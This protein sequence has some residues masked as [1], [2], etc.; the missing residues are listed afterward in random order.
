[1]KTKIV[2]LIEVVAVFA[3]TLTVVAVVG[4]STIGTAIRNA[5]DRAFLEYAAMIAVP[6]AVLL[7]SKRGLATYGLSLLNLRYHLAVTLTA[8]IPVAIASVA[9]V[10][11]DEKGWQGALIITAIQVALLFAIALL[12]RRK[13]TLGSA[14]GLAALV[15]VRIVGSQTAGP[16]PEKAVS[17]LVFYVLFLGLGEELLFRGYIQSRLNAAFGRPFSFYGVEWGWGAIVA[18]ALFG[19]MHVLNLGSY[20]NEQW[21]L[22]PWWGLWTFFG[23][24]VLAFVREKTGSI[25]APTLLH[26]LPQGIASAFLG[27]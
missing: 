9:F 5:T 10:F 3:I 22:T 17:A 19:L 8:F 2:A 15:L 11:L 7:V 24:L 27:L 25:V 16:A 23:G 26:G 14:N 20:V 18:S 13:P 12:L 4:A 6:L 1:M 21:Y